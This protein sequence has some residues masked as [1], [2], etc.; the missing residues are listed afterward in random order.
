MF[1][2][3]A[4]DELF[5]YTE[6]TWAVFGNAVRALPPG[7]FTR[8]VPGSGWP[9]LRDALFHIA[10]AWDEWLVEQT[11]AGLPI[12]QAE[13]YATWDA[14]DAQRTALRGLFRQLLD[15][16]DDVLAEQIPIWDGR[17][18]Q[19]RGEV[20]AHLLVHD[21]RHHGDITTLLFALGA[22]PPQSDYG[23]YRF[24]KSRRQDGRKRLGDA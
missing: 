16:P 23:V 1:D 12:E 8:A 18:T 22:E 7:D 6:Y 11:G 9:S 20:L 24:F 13:A 5:D 17:A 21:L 2:R 14:L 4:L 19:S 15:R 10:G 3:V